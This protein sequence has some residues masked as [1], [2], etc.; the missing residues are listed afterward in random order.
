MILMAQLTVTFGFVGA[1]AFSHNV[2]EFIVQNMW[3]FWVSLVGTIICIIALSC[4]GDLRRKTPHN[5]IF[6]GLFTVSIFYNIQS[7]ILMI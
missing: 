3:L 5:Y 7:D 6:L 1:F 2:Q 4:C